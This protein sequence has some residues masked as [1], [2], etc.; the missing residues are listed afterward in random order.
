MGSY[1]VRSGA[2]AAT[3]EDLCQELFLRVWR[4]RD[5]YEPRARFRTWLHRIAH[6]IAINDGTRNRWRRASRLPDP[7]EAGEA[8]PVEDTQPD[9][10]ADREERREQVRE[11]VASLPE[12]QRSARFVCAMCLAAPDGSVLAET[13]G[14]FEGVIADAPRGSNGFGYDPLLYL[15]VDGCTSAELEPE[16]KN[17]R[18]HRGAAAR[19][20]AD[21]ITA[22]SLLG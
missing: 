3:A 10:H 14:T 6:R 4:A 1:F 8:E 22:R 18:S 5:R 20:M 2:D 12:A 13:E 19:A 16:E 9:E 21:V 7:G 11:A 17:A 15:P